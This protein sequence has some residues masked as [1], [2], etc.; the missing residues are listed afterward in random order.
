MTGNY[1]EMMADS[2]T[3]KIAILKEMEQINA[4]QKALF[5]QGDAMDDD[6]FDASV[7]RKGELIDE[8]A[9]LNDGFT[10]LFNKVKEE[11]GD[12][13]EPYAAQIRDLQGKIREITEL[14]NSVQAQE[15]R[16]KA[17]A[18]RYFAEARG[19]L[20]EGKKSSN[21]AMIYYQTMSKSANVQPQ[22]FDNKK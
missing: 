6:A 15:A 12:N 10:A 14:S 17:I 20:K 22:F 3:R 16:N 1:L 11:S 5:E 4:E 2:L 13:R 8:I 7:D 19:R 21:T 9:K 18:D